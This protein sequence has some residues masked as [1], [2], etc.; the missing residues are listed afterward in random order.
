[1]VDLK[2]ATVVVIVILVTVRGSLCVMHEQ[3]FDVIRPDVFVDD[4]SEPN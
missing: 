1:V 4:L 2:F 3:A